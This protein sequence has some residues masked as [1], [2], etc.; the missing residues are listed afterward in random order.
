MR[1]MNVVSGIIAVGLAGTARAA[2]TSAV[3][4][5]HDFNAAASEAQLQKKPLFILASTEWCGPCKLMQRTTFMDPAVVDILNKKC[6]PLHVDGDKNKERMN[7]WRVAA[8]PTVMIVATSGSLREQVLER[9]EGKT[10]AP[11]ML[12]TLQRAVKKQSSSMPIEATTRTAP[13]AS[14]KRTSNPSEGPLQPPPPSDAENPVKPASFK[15]S[16]KKPR[17]EPDDVPLALGGHCPVSMVDRAEMAAGKKTESAVHNGK[18]YLFATAENRKRFLES[19]SKFLP[20]A[21][22][23]CVVSLVDG[24][25]R[26]DGDVKFPAIFGD[27]VFFLA[28]KPSREKFLKD[29]EAYVDS[30]GEPKT[31][32]TK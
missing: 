25:K 24:G 8:Y 14:A 6:I 10:D 19:P 21:G 9:F 20:G 22:G 16:E 32:K 30:K 1:A 23:D 17:P 28:D 29:P 11:D 7:Q 12:K 15:A 27:K 13:P 3:Q 2:E 5:R 31:A 4:W 26:M 18:K